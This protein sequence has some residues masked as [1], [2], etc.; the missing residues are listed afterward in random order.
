[1]YLLGGSTRYSVP[2]GWVWYDEPLDLRPDCR[3]EL[4]AGGV[5]GARHHEWDTK[6]CWTRFLTGHKEM[7]HRVLHRREGGR[8]GGEEGAVNACVR[9][10]GEEGGR[11]GEEQSMH[12]CVH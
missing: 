9:E 6:Q 1:M 2:V 12:V 10:G 8:E 7:L 5:V 4:S 11:G 3:M